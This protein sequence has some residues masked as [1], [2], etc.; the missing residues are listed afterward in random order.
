MGFK[1]WAASTSE[2]VINGL[3]DKM[4]LHKVEA[5]L[6]SLRASI[7]RDHGQWK[8]LLHKFSFVYLDRSDL[9]DLVYA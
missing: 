5:K 9:A 4:W 8:N 1:Q 6:S 7:D 3:F 2:A